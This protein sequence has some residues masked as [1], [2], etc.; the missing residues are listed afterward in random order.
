MAERT[1]PKSPQSLTIIYVFLTLLMSP[2][3]A[4]LIYTKYTRLDLMEIVPQSKDSCRTGE[5]VFRCLS[6][7]RNL[8]LR[9]IDNSVLI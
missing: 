6:I 4:K 1:K 8:K 3:I 5:G 9:K 2:Q 7:L